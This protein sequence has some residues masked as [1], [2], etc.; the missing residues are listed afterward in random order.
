LTYWQSRGSNPHR[1]N[2]VV[3]AFIPAKRDGRDLFNVDIEGMEEIMRRPTFI[4]W[5]LTR[6]NLSGLLTFFVVI[7]SI[8]VV[9]SLIEFDALLGNKIYSFPYLF[10]EESVYSTLSTIALTIV[11]IIG[12]VILASVFILERLI[13]NYRILCRFD[14]YDFLMINWRKH[15]LGVGMFAFLSYL[16]LQIIKGFFVLVSS[17]MLIQ[18]APNINATDVPSPGFMGLVDSARLDFLNFLG[19]VI[20]FMMIS[21][22]V[23]AYISMRIASSARIYDHAL[24]EVT[25]RIPKPVIEQFISKKEGGKDGIIDPIEKEVFAD[26]VQPIIIGYWREEL[27]AMLS[28]DAKKQKYYKWFSD[29]MD[30]IG[31]KDKE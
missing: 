19:G 6:T 8:T 7:Y 14:K 16:T 2:L 9:I 20:L 22:V 17:I 4:D 23:T 28:A 31:N 12:F 29:K 15:L 10:T 11:T 3:K 13:E 5:L 25:N 21:I 1:F 30:G 18:V 26:E 27:K 24:N